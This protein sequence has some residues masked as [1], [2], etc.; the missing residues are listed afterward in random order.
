M[1]K[2]IG[3]DEVADET[4]K[5]QV[6]ALT[7]AR[8]HLPVPAKRE[9]PALPEPEQLPQGKLE[10]FARWAGA[11]AAPRETLLYGMTL[12]GGVT[13]LL[14]WFVGHSISQSWGGLGAYMTASL[15]LFGGI[16]WLVKKH[17]SRVSSTTAPATPSELELAVRVCIG[18]IRSLEARLKAF[19]DAKISQIQEVRQTLENR[20][21]LD[22]R[23]VR[24][25]RISVEAFNILTT[26]RDDLKQEIEALGSLAQQT[27]RAGTLWSLGDNANGALERF[28]SL[29]TRIMEVGEEVDGAA[30]QYEKRMNDFRKKEADNTPEG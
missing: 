3:D 15:A 11:Q 5:R 18:N 12:G 8:E 19:F 22:A 29:T 9:L 16:K 24:D 23:D 13:L 17:R 2:P 1:S 25:K 6:S 20:E 14:Q 27:L 28:K 21:D 10:R 30:R 26:M 7:A 4:T